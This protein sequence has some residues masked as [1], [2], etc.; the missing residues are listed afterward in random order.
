MSVFI[1]TCSKC[2][3]S[4]QIGQFYKNKSTKDGRE[5]VCKDCFKE[6]AKKRYEDQR[7][8]C[9]HVV[10][11]RYLEK[12]AEVR[13]QNNK[14]SARWRSINKDRHRMNCKIRESRVRRAIPKWADFSSIRKLYKDA[15]IYGMEVDHIV[16]ISGKLVCGLHWEGNMQL[17]PK[18]E[19][20]R[21]GNRHWP[22]MP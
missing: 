15:E 8:H 3:S 9:I 1:K 18:A 14:A 10:K 7:E 5:T 6:R 12:Y 4:K 17:L 11:K 2:N 22:D 13:E 16:P 19:N 20:I 21:K